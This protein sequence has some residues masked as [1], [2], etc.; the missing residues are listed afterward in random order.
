MFHWNALQGSQTLPYCPLGVVGPSV[1]HLSFLI[2][3]GRD[4][5]LSW[6]TAFVGLQAALC[7]SVVSQEPVDFPTNQ[8][9]GVTGNKQ[10]MTTQS[11]NLDPLKAT[12]K[13]SKHLRK[14]SGS[15][16]GLAQEGP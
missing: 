1:S 9:K 5:F 16:H 14:A 2:S 15:V 3:F 13:I 7:S 8:N 6:V 4:C 10:S 12:W 11:N